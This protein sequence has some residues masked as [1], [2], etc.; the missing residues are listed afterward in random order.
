MSTRSEDI[1]EARGFG[2]RSGA[3]DRPALV[4]ID[5]CYGFTD[6]ASPLACDCEGA[7]AATA[8]LLDAARAGGHPVAFTTVQYDAAGR[9]IAAAFI[10]E[11]ARAAHARARD[12]LAA[13]RRAHRAGRERAGHAQALRV[14]VLRDLAGRH[15]RRARLRHRRRDRRVDVGLRP[16]DR[17]RRAAARLPRVVPREAVADR[18]EGAH[19]ATLTDLDAKY[20]DVVGIDEALAIFSR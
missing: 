12:A 16:R 8:R 18:A 11:G 14:R 5:L 3:G 4:V 19:Q 10:R 17:G 9:E 7:V 15:A 1:Y 20:G 2:G 6:P 13:D